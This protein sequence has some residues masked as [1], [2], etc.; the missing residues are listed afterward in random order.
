MNSQIYNQLFMGFKHKRNI[1][2]ERER[3]KEEREMEEKKDK[4]FIYLFIY[5]IWLCNLYY[6]I[7]LYVKIKTKILSVLLNE[8]VK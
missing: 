6:L 4:E 3:D 7:G 2:L 1:L 8:L 5:I